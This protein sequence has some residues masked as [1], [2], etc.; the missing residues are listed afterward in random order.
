[1]Q[2]Y[3]LDDTFP[4]SACRAERGKDYICPEC[5]SHVRVRAGVSRQIH[6][7][8]FRSSKNCRQNKKSLEHLQL[9]LK[10]FDLIGSVEAQIECPFPSI[11]RIADIAWHAQ[12]IVFEVQCSSIPL[13]EAKE[14]ILDYQ[15]IGYRVFWILHDKQFNKRLLSA[16][17]NY[18]RTTPC[19]FSNMNKIGQGVVYDQFEVLKRGRRIFKGAPLIVTPMKIAPIVKTEIL[20]QILPKIILNRLLSWPLHAKGDLLDRLLKEGILSA[21][22]KKMIVMESRLQKD[23]EESQPKILPLKKLLTN[24]YLSCLNWV[25]SK[26]G[27]TN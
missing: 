11:Q 16:S 8:H 13:D 25:L 24:S 3:A 19:Y 21:S 26:T 17:E 2:L 6:F 7:Y 18:L 20:G 12:K 15:K 10:L 1:M 9:Q 22:A 14:R 23:K 27:E 5:K 4:V